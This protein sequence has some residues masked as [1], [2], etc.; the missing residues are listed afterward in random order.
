MEI[1]KRYIK[2][3]E[4]LLNH[5]EELNQKSLGKY[6]YR[7]NAIE[8]QIE[9]LEDIVQGRRDSIEQWQKCLEEDSID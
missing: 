2:D 8:L 4:S 1:V 9:V 7:S 3:L 6:R 5:Y